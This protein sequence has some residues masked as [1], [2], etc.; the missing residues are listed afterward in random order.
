MSKRLNHW[1]NLRIS[2][3]NWKFQ[4]EITKLLSYIL[5]IKGNEMRHF[6]NLF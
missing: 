1:K 6:S 4:A 3:L 2:I 5:I